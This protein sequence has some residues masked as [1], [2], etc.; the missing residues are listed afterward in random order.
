[1][2]MPFGGG[3]TTRWQPCS[4]TTIAQRG[5]EFSA[6]STTTT[7]ALDSPTAFGKDHELLNE[8]HLLRLRAAQTPLATL[9]T[10]R[11]ITGDKKSMRAG[12]G[13]EKSRKSHRMDSKENL[14]PRCLDP[15]ANRQ[16]TTQMPPETDTACSQ[17]ATQSGVEV[18]TVQPP[19][20][21]KQTLVLP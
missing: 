4:D 5:D 8:L 14:R 3:N 7:K 18:T 10:F 1:M 12:H 19:L 13:A 16:Q 20:W 11:S 17:L 21:L 2:L 15:A 9:R 6:T